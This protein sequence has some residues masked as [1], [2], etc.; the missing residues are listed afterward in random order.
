[1]V[2][3]RVSPQM[4]EAMERQKVVDDARYQGL[5]M[6]DPEKL[7]PSL[8]LSTPMFDWIP[9]G[10]AIGLLGAIPA[11]VRR[12][13]A[14][15][16]SHLGYRDEPD[17]VPSVTRWIQ[18]EGL[19]DIPLRQGGTRFFNEKQWEGTLVK[20]D[21][22]TMKQEGF[23]DPKLLKDVPGRSGEIRGA[24]RNMDDKR[25]KGFK[26]D[27]EEH[28]IEEPILV[29]KDADGSIAI[30][31]GN[32]RLDAAIELGLDR[33]PVDFRYFGKSETLGHI[34]KKKKRKP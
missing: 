3:G 4:L 31:E 34:I 30:S 33:I 18:E 9:G 13:S 11:I 14:T 23:V 29:I 17:W 15:G 26:K 24:R 5:L 25:W 21:H 7:E 6:P 2:W 1:M 19:K 12:K 20:K 28:G 8:G 16:L 32:H 27:I 22:L 10:K